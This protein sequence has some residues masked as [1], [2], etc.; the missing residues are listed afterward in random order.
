MGSAITSRGV[1]PVSPLLNTEF[2]YI[3]V[4]VFGSKCVL[5]NMSLCVI[6]LMCNGSENSNR[7]MLVF[8]HS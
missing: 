2:I 8:H 5:S 3:Y 1:N 4:S 7:V 6:K